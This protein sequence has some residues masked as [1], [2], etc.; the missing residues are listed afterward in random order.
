[1]KSRKVLKNI[2]YILIP[3]FILILCI[4]IPYQ[5][6]REEE[7]VIDETIKNE[8]FIRNY[9]N[10]ISAY[11]DYLIY[12]SN[13][14]YQINDGENVIFYFNIR[15]EKIKNIDILIGYRNKYI[16]NIEATE[17]TDTVQEIK[18]YITKQEKK[19]TR[20]EN[21]QV[22]SDTENMSKI[23]DNYNKRFCF[24]YYHV[25]NTII[26]TEVEYDEE[27]YLETTQFSDFDIY[28]S[29]DEEVLVPYQEE[30]NTFFTLLEP[31]NNIMYVLIP[32]SSVGIILC[33][34]YLCFAIGKDNENKELGRFDKFF[35]E[36]IFVIDGFVIGIALSG[37]IAILE[38]YISRGTPNLNL[39]LSIIITCFFI[40]YIAFMLL[41]AT[42][43]RRIKAKSFWNTTII[44]KSIKWLWKWTKKIWNKIS[45][46]IKKLKMNLKTNKKILLYIIIFTLLEIF[47]PLMFN[48]IGVVLDIVLV[49][50]SYNYFMKYVKS[51]K[52]IENKL[53]DIYEG[54]NN[55]TLD[56]NNLEDEFKESAKY[57]TDI[58]NGLN[59]AIQKSVKSERLKAELITNVS[60]DIKTPLTSI[61]NYVDLLKKESIDNKKAEE[62]IQIIDSKSQRLKK[63]TEDLVEA[64]KASSGAI[65]LKLEK[66]NINELIK[67][68]IG[69]FK[70]KFN[71]KGLKID[72]S[73][74]NSN[75]VITADSR[76][77]YRV[78]ENLF[79]NISKYALENSRVYIEIQ[80]KQDK[81]III[82]KNISKEKLNISSD[83]LMQRFVRGD[84]ARNTEG[85][86]LGLSIAQSLTELQNGTFEIKIDGDLFKAQIEFPI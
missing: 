27:K 83:E 5:I 48:F 34:I 12:N 29:Y 60:H 20:I 62:Y 68:S 65:K 4:T 6:Y 25:N 37:I 43:V 57:I 80:E 45:F 11:A 85:S 58:S 30:L 79:S 14:Y 74:T 42:T 63:L 31:Y 26:E 75:T 56:E 84:K 70:D 73:Y 17:K 54:K 40:I 22:I 18:D 81:V 50:F 66:I 86:G 53:K 67:Q 7:N 69:E 41:F 13:Q 2:C 76:Y 44:G 72:T 23:A 28:T 3:I 78:I 55:I 59:N 71:S 15:D 24:N 16:T 51:Y 47:L 46:N 1:M 49:V 36:I 19:H 33:F 21:G 38:Q 82:I 8:E 35:Y 9:M 64:S 52:L 10:D 32:V 39:V 77:L 61:I